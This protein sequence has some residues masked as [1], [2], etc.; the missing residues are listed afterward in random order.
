MFRVWAHR[1]TENGVVGITHCDDIKDAQKTV[2]T[3]SGENLFNHSILP[4]LPREKERE[5]SHIDKHTHASQSGCFSHI[6]VQ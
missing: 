3:V 2:N 4:I 6:P 1:D 5:V